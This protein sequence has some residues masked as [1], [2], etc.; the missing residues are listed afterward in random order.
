MLKYHKDSSYMITSL[1][2]DIM[3]ISKMELLTELETLSNLDTFISPSGKEID[4]WEWI[5]INKKK[6]LEDDKN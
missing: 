6:V 1:V 2:E 4:L 3:K 5:E